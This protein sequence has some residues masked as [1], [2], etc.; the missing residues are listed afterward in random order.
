VEAQ[1]PIRILDALKWGDDVEKRFFEKGATELPEVTR[2]Y[3]AKNP[4]PFDV[5]A[6]HREFYD[7]ER[8][9]RRDMGTLNPAGQMMLRA[10]KE[11]PGVLS[12][13]ALRGTPESPATSQGLY[14]STFA[15]SHAGDPTLGDLGRTLTAILAR[16][17]DDASIATEEKTFDS[18]GA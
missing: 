8:D 15:R 4:L 3:Y 13:L 9:I 18:E 12:M 10:C 14:G 5:E 1:R 7:I 16:L 17:K 6:K 2:E 11:Y